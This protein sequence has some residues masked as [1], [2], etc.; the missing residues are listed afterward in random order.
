MHYNHQ[1]ISILSPSETKKSEKNYPNF[2]GDVKESLEEVNDNSI[3]FGKDSY[4]NQNASLQLR[5]RPLDKS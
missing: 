4:D 2:L 3:H 5:I 1:S